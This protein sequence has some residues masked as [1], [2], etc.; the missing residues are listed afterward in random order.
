M[1]RKPPSSI[2][3]AGSKKVFLFRSHA[4][5]MPNYSLSSRKKQKGKEAKYMVV[6]AG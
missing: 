3:G 6:T 1:M 2:S 4:G 5:L